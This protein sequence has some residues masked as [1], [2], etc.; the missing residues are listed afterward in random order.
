MKDL[1]NSMR[2]RIIASHIMLAV[3]CVVSLS[4]GFIL[5]MREYF[6]SFLMNLQNLLDNNRGQIPK[7]QIVSSLDIAHEYIHLMDVGIFI[8][9]ILSFFAAVIIGVFMAGKLSEPLRLFTEA[10][11]QLKD[12]NYAKIQTDFS[13]ELAE[14][15]TAYNGFTRVTKNKKISYYKC[16]S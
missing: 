7:G 16:Q 11:H 9:A 8:G 13:G 3:L 1:F 4:A 15:K 6:D 2:S 12:N 5:F 10:I 14:L